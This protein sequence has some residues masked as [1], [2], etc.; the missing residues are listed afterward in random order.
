MLLQKKPA[1]LLLLGN[2]RL[3]PTNS[4]T[5]GTARSITRPTKVLVREK[6]RPFLEDRSVL[7]TPDHDV[8]LFD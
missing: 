6:R 1:V 7:F 3:V 2:G 8:L 5:S 4:M